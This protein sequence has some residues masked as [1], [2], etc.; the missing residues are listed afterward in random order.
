[1]DLRKSFAVIILVSLYGFYAQATQVTFPTCPIG[2]EEK[3]CEALGKVKTS[4][5]L[6]FEDGSEFPGCFVATKSEQ[7]SK[8]FQQMKI[9]RF[10]IYERL[11]ALDPL[12]SDSSE[13]EYFRAPG[14]MLTLTRAD[15]SD[16]K[17]FKEYI[18]LWKTENAYQEL[19]HPARQTNLESEVQSI[20]KSI[21]TFA[22]QI[23]DTYPKSN[24]TKSE[25]KK[26]R[27]SKSSIGSELSCFPEINA[28]YDYYYFLVGLSPHQT[29]VP[30]ASRAFLIGHELCHSI[31]PC[32]KLREGEPEPE[33]EYPFQ[34]AVSCLRDDIGYF[35]KSSDAQVT[36]EQK[37]ACSDNYTREALC[38]LMSVHAIESRLKKPMKT[39]KKLVQ[40]KANQIQMPK[41][42][43]IIFSQL[44]AACSSRLSLEDGQTHPH[45]M[46]RLKEIMFRNPIIAKALNC[47]V[48]P[49]Q[50]YCDAMKGL[51]NAPKNKKGAPESS[52][53]SKSR[54]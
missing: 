54:N 39:T 45:Q 24:L 9:L 34:P 27:A 53:P 41:G 1:M 7:D 10:K 36:A 13:S 31:D 49:K 22:D 37:P 42:Y 29:Q 16:R 35:K 11:K 6:V 44:D 46:K 25:Y 23:P 5:T 17:L 33:M 40:L 18:Q 52:A 50:P 14:K 43:D 2:Q 4:D 15:E 3:V 26:I 51:V 19:K 21:Q 12:F 47:P 30:T 38:D 8:I 20:K 48:D 32:A 28:Y